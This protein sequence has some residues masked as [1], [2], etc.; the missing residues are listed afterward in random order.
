MML[1]IDSIVRARILATGTTLLLRSGDQE[2]F[3]N[4]HEIHWPPSPKE[5]P[6]KIFPIGNEIDVYVLGYLYSRG[7]VLGSIKRVDSNANPYRKLS[8]LEPG[9]ILRGIVNRHPNPQAPKTILLTDYYVIANL[10]MENPSTNE[11]K[12]RLSSGTEVS[13][14]LTLLDLRL[15]AVEVDIK[16]ITKIADDARSKLF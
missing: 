13:V 15:E 1:E 2:I 9:T 6:A 4:H 14:I 7:R 10:C 11:M 12:S 3:V 8:R 16:E 5:E